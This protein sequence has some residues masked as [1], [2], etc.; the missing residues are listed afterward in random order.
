MWTSLHITTCASVPMKV[1][2]K[3]LYLNHVSDCSP[4]VFTDPAISAISRRVR[5]GSGWS[6]VAVVKEVGGHDSLE[7]VLLGQHE[8]NAELVVVVILIGQDAAGTSMASLVVVVVSEYN[9]M[10]SIAEALQCILQS[11]ICF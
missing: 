11:S 7:A 8:C 1:V 6:L 2:A 3:K 10:K 5:L 4:S 9:S